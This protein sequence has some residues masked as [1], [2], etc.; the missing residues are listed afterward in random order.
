MARRLSDAARVDQARELKPGVLASPWERG[1][2]DHNRAYPFRWVWKDED[3]I[4]NG[5]PQMGAN[6]CK[7]CNK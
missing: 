1:T 6:G 5:E 7:H 4:E 3:G 2:C